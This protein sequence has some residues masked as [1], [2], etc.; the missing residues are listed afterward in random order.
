MLA[1]LGRADGRA[2]CQTKR[3]HGKAAEEGDGSGEEEGSSPEG[4]ELS[5]VAAVAT[6]ET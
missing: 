4:G 5:S 3:A 6:L 2:V 1:G